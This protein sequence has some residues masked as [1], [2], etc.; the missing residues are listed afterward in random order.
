MDFSELLQRIN[1]MPR[2]H[3]VLGYALFY[4]IILGGAYSFV[5]SPQADKIEKTTKKLNTIRGKLVQ[6][7]GLDRDL[8]IF[9]KELAVMQHELKL[10]SA[11]LPREDEIPRLLKQVSDLGTQA[12]LEFLLFKPK[13]EKRKDF[14]SQVPVELKFEGGF[15]NVCMFFDTVSKLS[16]IVNIDNIT[17]SSPKPKNGYVVVTTR[18][19]ATTF[20]YVGEANKNVSKKKR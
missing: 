5:Y 8:K 4:L 7:R 2:S 20:K 13:S 11:M 18:C 12:G 15:H 19:T 1:D 6:S 14:Y 16:R 10:V 17:I 9:K 3:L